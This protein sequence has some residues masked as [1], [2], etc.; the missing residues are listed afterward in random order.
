MI[1][2]LAFREGFLGAVLPAVIEGT[3]DDAKDLFVGLTDNYIK[4]A[5]H[6]AKRSDIGKILNVKIT[7]V[8]DQRTEGEVITT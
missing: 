5:A 2:N 6:G 4:V 7:G 3:Q 8:E 1:K